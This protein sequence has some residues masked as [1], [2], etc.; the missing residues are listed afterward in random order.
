MAN[1]YNTHV[2]KMFIELFDATSLPHN[3]QNV[4]LKLDHLIQTA[5]LSIDLTVLRLMLDLKNNLLQNGSGK[6]LELQNTENIVNLLLTLNETINN[7]DFNKIS[8]VMKFMI[9]IIHP[10]SACELLDQ[11]YNQILL[12]EENETGLLRKLT[13]CNLYFDQITS[14]NYTSAPFMPN[15]KNLILKHCVDSSH[16]VLSVICYSL[17]PKYIKLVNDSILTDIIS[18][19]KSDTNLLALCCM[20]DLLLTRRHG[21]ENIIE[22]SGFWVGLQNSLMI[23]SDKKFALF[24]LKRSIEVVFTYYDHVDGIDSIIAFNENN[25]LEVKQCFE[26]FVQVFEGLEGTQCH[27]IKP[28]LKLLP[29]IENLHP[30]WSSI[31]YNILLRHQNNNIQLEAIQSLVEYDFENQNKQMILKSTFKSLIIA[32]NN[33]NLYS[34]SDLLC[35]KLLQKLLVQ[36]SDDLF[37]DFMKTCVEMDKW[38]TVPFFY[39]C[40]TLTDV[41]RDFEV[42]LEKLFMLSTVVLNKYI[43]HSC[44]CLLIKCQLNFLQTLS[45]KTVSYLKCMIRLFILVFPQN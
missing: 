23:E 16:K 11:I 33:I 27:I 20:S 12:F 37:A 38:L 18:K 5:D 6:H 39:F 22:L 40:N 26:N 34:T 31:I 32:L 3:K 35:V 44:Q 25:K 21:N 13:L 17:L 29:N 2:I 28:L 1:L 30:S 7:T 43:R 45:T 4:S 9:Q 10:K 15:L 24:L 36:L 41:G 42:F 14:L 19:L 8:E